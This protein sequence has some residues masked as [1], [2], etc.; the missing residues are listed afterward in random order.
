MT[1]AIL[2]SQILH[3]NRH[4][5]ETFPANSGHDAAVPHRVSM[6]SDQDDIRQAQQ[7]LLELFVREHRHRLGPHGQV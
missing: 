7:R 5:T 6:A 1:A 3:P 2:S 4:N